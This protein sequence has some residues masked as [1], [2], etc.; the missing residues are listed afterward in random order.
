MSE[1]LP[2]LNAYDWIALLVLVLSMAVGM[3]RGFV[4][5]LASIGAWFG[6][7]IAARQG[8][9]P[10]AAHAERL[11]ENSAVRLALCFITIF[12]VTLIV[13][14]LLGQWMAQA[15]RKVGLRPLDRVLGAGFGVVRAGL[16]V[17]VL[18]MLAALTGVTGQKDWQRAAST[19]WLEKMTAHA[20]AILPAALAE[21]IH[22]HG[23][24]VRAPR[25]LTGEG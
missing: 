5:E 15:V 13:I 23:A 20:T 21:R 1:I 18:V 10:L 2:S 8:A 9:E 3:L 7:F 4:R 16:I 17:M 12:V 25:N 22:L 6:A 14:G 19:A 24:A 11:L